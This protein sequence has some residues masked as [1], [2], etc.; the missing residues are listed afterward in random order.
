[1]NRWRRQCTVVTA[2]ATAS[3]HHQSSHAL[4]CGRSFDQFANLV[5]E[6]SSERIIVG[7]QYAEVALGL[8]VVR[9]LSS[10]S[11]SWQE[12]YSA[13]L[14]TCSLNQGTQLHRRPNAG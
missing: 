8:Y 14:W 6:D 10:L 2:C 1:M 4:L 11:C 3:A 7:T 5:L 9:A 12:A 13:M